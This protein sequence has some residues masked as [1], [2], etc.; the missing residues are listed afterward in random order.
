MRQGG[1]A[2]SDAYMER[3]LLS[4]PE[5]TTLLVNLF[6]ARF[7]PDHRSSEEAERLTE[8]IEQQIDAVQSLDEDR[9]LRSFL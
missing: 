6:A 8:E 9:I 4:H 2:F 7:D 3:T 5:I 1:I